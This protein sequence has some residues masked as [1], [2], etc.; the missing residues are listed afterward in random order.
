MNGGAR[1]DGKARN[2]EA[3]GKSCIQD[4]VRCKDEGD[5]LENFHR[6]FHNASQTR[7][8]I[9]PE[10]ECVERLLFFENSGLMQHFRIIHKKE[11]NAKDFS[12]SAEIMKNKYGQETLKFISLLSEKKS[13]AQV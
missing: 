13:K 3:T 10:T 5:N 9:C 4:G 11:A 7:K 1:K 8:V 6:P 2:C 12:K